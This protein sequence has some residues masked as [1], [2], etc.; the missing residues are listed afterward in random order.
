MFFKRTSPFFH[1]CLLLFVCL[2][3]TEKVSAAHERTFFDDFI[4]AGGQFGE[5]SDKQKIKNTEVL[6]KLF[7]GH[8]AIVFDE[9]KTVQTLNL[10][11]ETRDHSIIRNV[12]L[13]NY[14]TEITPYTIG[15]KKGASYQEISNVAI[16]CHNKN[17]CPYGIKYGYGN[18]CYSEGC[19]LNNITISN[20][21]FPMILY[22]WNTVVGRIDCYKCDYGPFLLGTS[23]TVGALFCNGCCNGPVLGAVLDEKGRIVSNEKTAYLSYSTINVIS[24]DGDDVNFCVGIGY[25]KYVNIGTIGMEASKASSLIAS[26]Y[27][28]SSTYS[29]GT[30]VPEYCPNKFYQNYA[31]GK[32][33]D[34]FNV[35]AI[36]GDNLGKSFEHS[37]KVNL[38][39]E[40]GNAYIA[41]LKGVSSNIHLL[42]PVVGGGPV[43]NDIYFGSEMVTGNG[44]DEIVDVKVSNSFGKYVGIVSNNQRIR[45]KL[46]GSASSAPS[47]EAINRQIMFL[48]K[49]V[50][51]DADQYNAQ[52]LIGETL[53]NVAIESY[54]KNGTY[55]P[56]QSTQITGIKVTIDSKEDI[57]SIL[58]E[59][60]HGNKNQ[61]FNFLYSLE[62][63][64]GA[65]TSVEIEDIVK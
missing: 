47:D 5:V 2:I 15:V 27:Q 58:I 6:L 21:V 17:R 3:S 53:I 36:F 62:C 16:V 40:R 52:H 49:L 30:I 35:S 19:S 1:F 23:L 38:Y 34:K 56:S 41:Q 37:D 7:N 14:Y 22:T 28:S 42:M 24:V 32:K 33:L 25:A 4:E 29:V 9:K 50:V 31:I 13:D 48:G 60:P 57:P 39:L 55:R 63:F 10:C 54:K 43:R 46:R 18:N 64:G 20:Y 45:I 59:F 61:S 26:F 65:Y 44:T 11:L 8:N 51:G 12:I